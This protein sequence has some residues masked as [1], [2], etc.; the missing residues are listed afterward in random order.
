MTMMMMTMTIMIMLLLMLF[1]YITLHY[2]GLWL[3]NTRFSQSTDA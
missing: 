1:H 2:T 3:P